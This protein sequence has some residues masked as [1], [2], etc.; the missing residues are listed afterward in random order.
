MSPGAI[1]FQTARL[2]DTNAL[3][4]A[5]RGASVVIHLA[6]HAHAMSATDREGLYRAVNVEGS[7]SV[8]EAAAAESVTHLVFASSVKAIGEGG[9]TAVSD[10]TPPHPVDTYGESKLEAEKTL[11][12]IGERRRVAV[13]VLRLP[14]V[15]GPGVKGNMRRILDAVS[16]GFPLPVGGVRNERSMLGIDNLTALL[17]RILE[18]PAETRRPMLVS[19]AESVST[20]SLVRMI[21]SALGKRPRILKL[22]PG[23]IRGLG[24]IGDFA[25]TIGLQFFSSAAADRL[26]HSLRVDSSRAWQIAGFKPPIPLDEGIHRVANWYRGVSP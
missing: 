17:A 7:R 23:I 5:F 12:E 18:L 15:Y 20:E 26:L 4:L 10:A 3:R 2:D 24:E 22:P 11:Y 13:S 8:G 14:L 6:G 21:A 19:D 1:P 9:A 16:R 25:S